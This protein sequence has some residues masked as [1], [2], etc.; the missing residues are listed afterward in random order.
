MTP[1]RPVALIPAYKPAPVLVDIAAALMASEVFEAVICVDDGGGEAY[2]PLFRR[3]EEMGVEVLHHAVNL[4]KGQALKTGFNHALLHWPDSIGVV[5]LDADG[6]H[7]PEDVEAVGRALDAEPN[8]LV[9]GCRSFHRRNRDIPWRS[10]WGNRATCLAMRLFTGLAVSD[11][12]TGLRGVP[13]SML[14]VLLR[15]KAMRYEYETDMLLTAKRHNVPLREVPIRTVY[16]EG[17]PT[18]H[19][20]PLWDSMRIYFMLLRFSSVSLL[21]ALLDY[22]LF[23]ALIVFFPLW[24]ALPL[25]RITAAVFQF[26]MSA[27]YVFFAR[28]RR[29]PFLLRYAL[30]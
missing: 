4:G 13:L 27:R 21:T 5:T 15:L 6:Q 26:V 19:F 8:R 18:S 7:L 23:A 1:S 10:R 3:L 25:A 22:A 29:W 9:L 24:L 20:N 30:V 17:N 28:G 11:T 2:A 16:E 12:Q 14:P